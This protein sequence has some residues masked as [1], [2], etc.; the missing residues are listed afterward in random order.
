MNKKIAIIGIGY[1]GLPLTIEFSK[2]FEVVGF[3]TDQSRVAH[4]QSKMKETANEF[5]NVA[6]ENL[7]Y[8]YKVKDILDCDIYIIT[9]PTPIDH[10]KQP[11][12]NQLLDAT[13]IVGSVLDK[14][15][16]VIFESTVYPGCTEEDCVPELEKSS[17]LRYNQD[18]FCGYSPERIN[19]GD[20]VNT[21]T[22]IV[23][24]T[25]GSTTEI[26]EEIDQLYASII[27]AGTYKAGSIR[28][29][30]ASKAIENAQRDLNISF[31]NE[32]AFIFD[33]M[34]IDTNDVLDAAATKWNFI[35]F[36]PGL[37]GG[38]CIGVDPYY[39]TYKSE[40]LGYKPAV[41]L[42]GRKVNEDITDFVSRKILTLIHQKQQNI[43]EP[44][45]LILGFTFKENCDDIR[46]SRVVELFHHLKSQNCLVDIYDPWANDK[47]VQKEYS[48]HLLSEISYEKY[49]DGI[50][51]AVAHSE[52]INIDY[53]QFRNK[54]TVIY[55]V[56]AFLPRHLVDGR[57]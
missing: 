54:G 49:Y 14:G 51:L 4:L 2:K 21:L 27:S 57:L 36:K 30:E 34:N 39:L 45:I 33:K 20:N 12:L 19:V 25:S 43:I 40:K 3:D 26:A 16:I 38:H 42:S 53:Q 32:L 46:N 41:L 9:V 55:D 22:K 35:K 10:N 28:V 31:V 52:F 17:G 13:R 48:L 29:A 1:V 15:N 18:F 44:K 7:N 24:V 47:H 56:K 11:D 5:E 6:P 23:K 50:V 8:T 37:V